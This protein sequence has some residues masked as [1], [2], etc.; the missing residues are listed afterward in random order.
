MKE[1]IHFTLNGKSQRMTV[2]GERMLLWVLRTDLGLTGTK[3]G[4]GESF[5]GTCTVLVNNK[6]VRSCQL[7]VKDLKGKKVI[8]IEGLSNNGNL[9]P[10]QK[11]FIKHNALQCGFCTPGMIL[12]AYSLLI[13]NPQPKA[14]EILQGMED[15]LCRCGSHTRIVQ[16][17]KTAAQEMRGGKRR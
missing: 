5:C 4:C 3:F 8:T 6:A 15:N 14:R 11:A 10:L 2:D 12:N 1:T 13:E 9:H 17:I 7:P 16:A